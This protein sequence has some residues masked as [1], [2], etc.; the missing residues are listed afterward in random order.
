MQ[1]EHYINLNLDF[2][3]TKKVNIIHSEYNYIDAPLM[4]EFTKY[5]A[6]REE[7]QNRLIDKFL[8]DPRK[9]KIILNPINTSFYNFQFDENLDNFFIEKKFGIFVSSYWNRF[10][11]KA[12]IDFAL[13]CKEMNL[14]CVLVTSCT[15]NEDLE[16]LNQLYDKIIEPT[17]NINKIMK[18]ASLSGGIQ[19]GR[20][21]WEA[22]L[23]GLSVVE[24]IVDENGNIINEIYESATDQKELEN[25]KKMTNPNYVVSQILNWGLN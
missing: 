10:R 7:I 11:F 6:I 18:N 14:H 20:T 19:K 12:M 24:Y 13:F 15:S 1:S 17:K 9:I 4:D 5:V 8:I 3:K 25:I 16:I 23:L 21:Y 22:K 2:K